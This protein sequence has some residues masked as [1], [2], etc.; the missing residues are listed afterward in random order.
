M[1]CFLHL[2]IPGNDVERSLLV[3]YMKDVQQLDVSNE[4]ALNQ[5]ING[6]QT[7]P[8]SGS[9]WVNHHQMFIKNHQFL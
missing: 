6:H 7:H 1:C 9:Q 4:A 5:L 2:V 3:K 8:G